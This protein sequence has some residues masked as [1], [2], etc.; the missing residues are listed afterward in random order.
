MHFTATS[1]CLHCILS[2]SITFLQGLKI[3]ECTCR[4]WFKRV[5]SRT[6]DSPP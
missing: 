5:A 1:V 3:E 4:P 6:E 2:D